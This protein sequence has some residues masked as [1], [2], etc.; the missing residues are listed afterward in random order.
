MAYCDLYAK[1]CAPKVS[2]WKVKLFQMKQMYLQESVKFLR[3]K[4][5]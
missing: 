4:D 3:G 2:T 1:D 5:Y